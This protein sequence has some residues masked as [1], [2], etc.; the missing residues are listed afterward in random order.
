[1]LYKTFGNFFAALAFIFA[2]LAI[3]QSAAAYGAFASDSDI[4]YGLVVNNTVSQ[5]AANEEATRICRINGGGS[6]CSTNLFNRIVTNQCA[7]VYLASGYAGFRPFSYFSVFSGLGNTRDR[8][9]SRALRFGELVDLSGVDICDHTCE[10]GETANG[11]DTAGCHITPT[12]EDDSGINGDDSGISVTV[13]PPSVSVTTAP[14]T[15]DDSDISVTVSPPS[16]SVTTAP[17]TDDSDISVTVSPP[18]VSVTTAPPTDDSDISVTVSPPNVSVTTAPPTDDSDISVTVSP[19]N[20]SVTTAPPTDDSDISVTVSPPPVD[21]SP[22]TVTVTV[23][24]NRCDGIVFI[25]DGNDGC[26]LNSLFCPAPNIVQ[27]PLCI[28]N[29]NTEQ[30]S[31]VMITVTLTVTVTVDVLTEGENVLDVVVPGGGLERVTVRTEAGTTDA[32][33]V[34]ASGVHVRVMANE[35]TPAMPTQSVSGGGG[36]SSGGSAA[37]I[38]GG[39]VVVGLALW[40]FSSGGDDLSWTP[41]YAFQNNNGNISYSVGSRWTATANDWDLYW[42]TR[43]NGDRFVYGS[44]MHYNG[45]ILSAAMNSESENDKTDLDL[46]LSANKT[47]GLW[48][49]GG[50]YRF[51]M[52]LSDD[53]TETQNRLNAQVRYT[54]DKWILSANANTDGDKTRAAINYSYRF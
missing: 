50:G 36:G 37:G 12:D 43:Q 15:D 42:Q 33:G 19:P 34:L 1:M 10:D 45:D 40:Y 25:D 4:A 35:I 49:F 38:I 41:S 18:N 53:A 27:G 6:R 3:H 7:A 30:V 23:T 51:D 21:D 13:S 9:E 44:G 28:A 31:I 32:I 5:T 17:P 16:V 22:P 52:E 29:P 39:V 14:P 46:N 11:P 54:L 47:V 24:A 26:E 48:N 20:V 8:A 2:A